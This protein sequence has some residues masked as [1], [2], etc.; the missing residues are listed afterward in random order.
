MGLNFLLIYPF[1]P[2]FV[3]A[4]ANSDQRNKAADA[5]WWYQSTDAANNTILTI[6][7]NEQGYMMTVHTKNSRQP[8][9]NNQNWLVIKRRDRQAVFAIYST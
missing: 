6:T 5:C 2:G 3:A 4:A 1:L 9:V 8:T 7:V